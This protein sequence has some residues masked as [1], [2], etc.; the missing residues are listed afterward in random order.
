MSSIIRAVSIWGAMAWAKAEGRKWPR[1]TSWSDG[2]RAAESLLAAERCV[3]ASSRRVLELE[4]AAMRAEVDMLREKARRLHLRHK[5]RQEH[6]F[7]PR[8][9]RIPERLHERWMDH[10]QS[11]EAWPEPFGDEY[12][13]EAVAQRL[14][15]GQ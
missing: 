4:R 8:M 6:R 12:P 11:D 10:P 9:D 14:A 3:V 7:D 5:W 2:Y 1:G 15:N 13:D